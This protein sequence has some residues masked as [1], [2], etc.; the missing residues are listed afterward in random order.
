MEPAGSV[1]ELQPVDDLDGQQEGGLHGE[2][3]PAVLQHLLL[4]LQSALSH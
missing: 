3:A 1:E 4:A 2:L